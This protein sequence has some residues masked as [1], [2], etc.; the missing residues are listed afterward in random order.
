MFLTLCSFAACSDDERNAEPLVDPWTRE[1]TPVNFRLESQIGSAVITNDWRND[2]E[3]TIHVSLI[4]G[5]LDMSKV[6]VNAIDFQFPQSEF[7]PRASVQAG[8]YIDLSSGSAQVTITAY[9]GETRVYTVDYEQF[10]DPL[11]GTYVHTPL[12]GILDSSNAPQ[13]SMVIIGG[14]TDTIVMSTAMDKWWHWGEGY[15]PTDEQDNTLSFMLTDA[16]PETGLTRGTLMNLAG[17]DG[18]Y[19]NYVYNNSDDVNA[20]YRIFPKGA[21]RWAKDADENIHVYDINDTEYANELY[22]VKP[23]EGGNYTFS[24]KDVTI[25]DC[26]F[27]REHVME[28]VI[29]WNWPDSRW[30]SNNLR[31]TFWMMK[32]I[33]DSPVEGHSDLVK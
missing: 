11:E 17:E 21:S 10:T 16:D 2:G 18:K 30:M 14:W 20:Y 12:P 8:D 23:L 3:G 24:T 22:V 31:N 13:C 9:N 6:K 26:A 5:A 33:S 4:T 27:M 1:R 32:K 28:E 7:C 15:N 19:A 25:N 29:D